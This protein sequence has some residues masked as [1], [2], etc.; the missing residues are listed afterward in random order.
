VRRLVVLAIV[1]CSAFGSAACSGSKR[2]ATC[3]SVIHDNAPVTDFG[4]RA[5][6]GST[7]TVDAAKAGFTP[8]CYTSVP[9][10]TV[11]LRVRNTGASL[12]NVD[13]VA[14]HVSLDVARGET[15]VVH[16]R[17]GNDPVVYVC[18]YH[19]DLGMVGVLVPARGA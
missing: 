15:A 3:A 19:R 16:L 9:R 4:S 8:T 13:V 10:G 5:A 17:V 18:T 12:H 14:Q 6:T 11:T 2:A 7:L 1:A